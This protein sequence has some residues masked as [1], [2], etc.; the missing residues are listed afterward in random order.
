MRAVSL[1]CGSLALAFATIASAQSTAP[2]GQID[3]Y[4][5]PVQALL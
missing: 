2:I 1:L 3:V 4:S 5:Q